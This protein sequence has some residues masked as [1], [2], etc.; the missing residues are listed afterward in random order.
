MKKKWILSLAASVM[1]AQT[2]AA[3]H[4]DD[5]HER[6]RTEANLPT[7][8]FTCKSLSDC[9][10]VSVPCQSDLAVNVGHSAEAQEALNEKYFFCLGSALHD[11]VASCEAHQCVTK[12]TKK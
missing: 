1:F 6:I 2:A 12:G 9:V 10:L 11:T 8:W 3:H 4:L 5:Y 7:K